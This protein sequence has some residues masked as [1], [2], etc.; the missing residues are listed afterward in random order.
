[1][2]QG[3]ATARHAQVQVEFLRARQFRVEPANLLQPAFPMQHGRR[4]KLAL[5]DELDRILAAVRALVRPH[6]RAVFLLLDAVVAEHQG[7]RM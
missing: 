7:V 3:G 1:M 6:G 5:Q 4:G 2:M